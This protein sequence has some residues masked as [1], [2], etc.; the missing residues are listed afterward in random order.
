MCL[1]CIA[2]KMESF[3]LKMKACLN[4]LSKIFI[5]STSVQKELLSDRFKKNT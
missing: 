5:T 3:V 4:V 2:L 1:R